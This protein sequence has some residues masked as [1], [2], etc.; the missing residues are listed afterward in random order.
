MT[1]TMCW[2]FPAAETA[3][4][5][6]VDGDAIGTIDGAHDATTSV[7]AASPATTRLNQRAFANAFRIGP[8]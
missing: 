4:L 8:Q 6:V 7:N 3:A 5:P 2:I 1:M